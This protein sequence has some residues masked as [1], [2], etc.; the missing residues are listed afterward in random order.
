M[1]RL[2]HTPTFWAASTASLMCT[3]FVAALT[4]MPLGGCQGYRSDSLYRSDI[5]TVYVEMFQ[6]K[7]F[8]RGLEYNLS[9][10]VAQQVEL[11]T[12]YRVTSDRR[13]AD[14][15]LRGTIL[16]IADHITTRQ[17]DV[18]RPMD[19]RTTVVIEVTWTNVKTGQQLMENKKFRMTG[20]YAALQGQDWDTAAGDAVE[21][22]AVR[23]VEAMETPWQ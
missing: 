16:S 22:L 2:T 23:L 4:L 6:S 20:S 3:L 1:K 14:T 17:G 11:K 8:R 5:D 12:P 7:S 9:R 21:D 13:R 19:S 15:V 10:A 18:G